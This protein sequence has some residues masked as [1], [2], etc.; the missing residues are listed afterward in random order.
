MHGPHPSTVRVIQ[1][2]RA[3]ALTRNWYVAIGRDK[4]ELA[5]PT[6]TRNL[7]KA[8]F[9]LCR[10]KGRGNRIV[11]CLYMCTEHG[12]GRPMSDREVK[13]KADG[14]TG[15]DELERHWK[16]AE[17]SVYPTTLYVGGVRPAGEKG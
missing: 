11:G 12:D 2:C 9:I 16:D 7:E 1:L 17:L 3:S 14:H 15:Q 10:D 6:V 4:I 8:S 5:R 13:G